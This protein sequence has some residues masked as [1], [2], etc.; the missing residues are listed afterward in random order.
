MKQT[1]THFDA[2]LFEMQ[3]WLGVDEV[4]MRRDLILFQDHNGFDHA[5]YSASGL[6]VAN[7]GLYAPLIR[8]KCQSLAIQGMNTKI[9]STS[10]WGERCCKERLTCYKR[11]ITR[12]KTIG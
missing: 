12:D 3:S 10:V 2:S 1:W 6:Q 9:F 4:K 11:G 5:R 7:I 8:H